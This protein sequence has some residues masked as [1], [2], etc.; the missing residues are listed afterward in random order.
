MSQEHRLRLVD[1]FYRQIKNGRVDFGIL[2]KFGSN[3]FLSATDKLEKTFAVTKLGGV[4]FGTENKKKFW[5][6]RSE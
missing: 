1:E 6:Y 5:L 4:E 2:E 3:H